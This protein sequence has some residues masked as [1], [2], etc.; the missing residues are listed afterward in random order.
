MQ[1]TQTVPQIHPVV[2]PFRE[3]VV[4]ISQAKLELIILLRN[5]R[6]RLKE[7]LEEAEAEVRAALEANA[8]VEPG[9]HVASLKES[10]RRNV[11]WREVAERLGDRF[12]GDGKGEGYC[13]KVLQSTKPTRT[14]SLAVL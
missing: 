7:Q 9:V 14:V 10:F 6:E 3:P 5:E 12:Y 13:E 4:E 1:A 8:P 11:A 2:V